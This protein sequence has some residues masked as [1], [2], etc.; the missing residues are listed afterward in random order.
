MG[1]KNGGAPR[2][3]TGYGRVAA[4][5]LHDF[6]VRAILS[7]YILHFAFFIPEWWGR[8]VLP[9][10]RDFHRVECELLHYAPHKMDPLAGFAPA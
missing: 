10:L 9:P 3:R 8:R 2:S 4:C 7:F 5:W 1:K 6:T